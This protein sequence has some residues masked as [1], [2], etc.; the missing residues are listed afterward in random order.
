MSA[1][2]DRLISAFERGEP[3]PKLPAARALDRIADALDRAYPVRPEAGHLPPEPYAV[4]VVLAECPQCGSTSARCQGL[5]PGSIHRARVSR[6]IP[7]LDALLAKV[8]P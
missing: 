7:E 5:T 3:V 1:L 6:W 8:A 2:F 4:V